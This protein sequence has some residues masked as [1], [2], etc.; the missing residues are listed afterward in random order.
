MTDRYQFIATQASQYPVALLCRVLGVARSGY[1]A[2]R[3]RPTSRRA[4]A[5]R[6]LAAQIQQVHAASRRTDGSPR[7]HAE[8]RAQGTCCS[9]KRVAR[10][11]RLGGIRACRPRR[12]RRTTDSRHT[13]PVAANLLDRAFGAPAA[14]TKWAADITYVETGEGWLYLAVILDLFSRRVVGWAMQA[15]RARALVLDALQM[16]LQQRRPRAPLVHHSDRGSQYASGDYQ[17]HLAAAGIQCSMSDP[18]DC[19]DNAPVESFFGTLKTEL[20]YQQ[21]FATRHE[22]RQAIFDYVEVF[23]NRQRRHSALGYVS[24]VAF[25]ARHAATLNMAQAA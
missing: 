7:V 25:E 2:W 15:T 5:N 20:V 1:Y 11:M 24:P 10:L 9:A 13:L 17:G 12:Q 4:E 18:G 22:A 8:L 14:N 3:R 16:A 19:F 23:Y 6:Q 21:R